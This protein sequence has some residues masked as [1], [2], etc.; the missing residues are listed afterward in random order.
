[1]DRIRV[2]IGVRIGDDDIRLFLP[3]RPQLL[4]LPSAMDADH[5]IFRDSLPAVLTK[6][7]FLRRWL[8]VQG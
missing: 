5:R 4:H 8:C 3:F 1:M 2:R 7:L 6:L